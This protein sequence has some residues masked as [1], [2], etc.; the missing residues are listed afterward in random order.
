M[1]WIG[2]GCGDGVA[3]VRGNGGRWILGLDDGGGVVRVRLL[4]AIA[5]S[6]I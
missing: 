2:V 3:M 1:M 5:S 4:K 6:M